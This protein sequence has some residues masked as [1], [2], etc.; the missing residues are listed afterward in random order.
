MARLD[1]LA[2]AKEVAHVGAA[3]GR[4]F[5]HDLLAAVLGLAEPALNAALDEL[6]RSELVFRR[7]MAPA[8]TYIFK[9]ALIRDTAYDSMLKSQRVL[10]HG[11]IAAALERV[12]PETVAAQP[13][14]AAHHYQEGGNS[15]AAFKYWS[16]AG[17]LAV[18]R[19]ACREAVTHYRCALVQLSKLDTAQQSPD[20]E[21]DLQMQLG[22][23]LMQTEGYGS[24]EAHSSYAR[25]RVLAS[26]LGQIDKYVIACAGFGPALQA[27]GRFGDIIEMFEQLTPDQLSR[28]EPMSRV[29]HWT[30]MGVARFH[31]GE[32]GEA[33]VNFSK[34][35]RGVDLVALDL[36]QPLSGVE[37][38]IL[39]LAY[40]SR[41]R[42][43]EGFLEQAA[44]CTALA[45]EVAQ[46]GTHAPTRTLALQMTAWTSLLKGDTE[47]AVRCSKELLESSQR[48]GLKTRIAN[49]LFSLGRASVATGQPDEGMQMLREGYA[50]WAATGGKFHCSS[51]ASEAAEALLNAERR[52]DAL[53]FILAGEK[54]Q[55]ESEEYHYRAELLRLRGRLA[56]FD[57]DSAA[58]LQ[59]YREA[60]EIAER[61]GA[62]LFSLRAATDLT[63]LRQSNGGRAE[64]ED[65][66]LRPIYERFTE[67]FDYPDLVRART[68]LGRRQSISISAMLS[69][70]GRPDRP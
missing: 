47:H 13:E 33:W 25:A 16:I 50:L 62:K 41:N 49:A 39:I 17:D 34:A 30:R 20:R 5:S 15:A 60:I 6:V 9:H 14:L 64:A 69:I 27:A 36:Q 43:P 54:V 2:P 63:R 42:V 19:S 35:R 12:Q 26:D 32:F 44:E 61:Q 46:R 8:A 52:D 28:L 58:A 4:E 18:S 23:A 55:N 53:E 7:G 68:M 51:W 22:N 48:F 57:G 31:R 21:L 3:I 59:S 45:V 38:M 10:R 66:L 65:S 40:S 1:R 67:G 70:S 11:Q 24:R 29:S 56:E 37:P